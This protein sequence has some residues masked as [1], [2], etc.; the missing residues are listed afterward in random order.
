MALFILKT[1]SLGLPAV[2]SSVFLCRDKKPN[3]SQPSK[4]LESGGIAN[5]P[6]IHGEVVIMEEGEM[7]YPRGCRGCRVKGWEDTP[8]LVH[9]KKN[10]VVFEESVSVLNL[11]VKLRDNALV[12]NKKKLEKAEKERDELKLKLEKFQ[13]LSK[14]LNNLLEGQVSDKCKTELGYNVTTYVVE[15]FMNSSDMLKSKSDKGYHVVPPPY[16]GNYMPPKPDLMFIDE[17]VE[18]ESVDVVSIIA[19]SNVKTVESKHETVDKSVFNTVE[20]NT[21]R[22]NNF[23]P[24]V[25]EDWNSDDECEVEFKSNVEAKTVKPST[26]KIKFVKT[27]RETVEKVETP[28]QNKHHPRR[29]QRN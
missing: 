7:S 3:Q 11:E 23:S 17:H 12:E 26:K 29:N 1:S 8:R 9:Y 13:N 16:T 2:L 4:S 15:S 24:P 21:V 10:E 6:I 5:L 28:E 22:K 20:S 14:S 27:T 19:S 25:I 18:S